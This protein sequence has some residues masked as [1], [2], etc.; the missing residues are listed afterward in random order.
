MNPNSKPAIALVD[1][2]PA[3]REA[4]A[5]LLEDNGFT[6]LARA[7]GR[8]E[9]LDISSNQPDLMLVDIS[10]G[11]EDGLAIVENMQL[12]GIP[13]VVCSTH[14]EP[15]YVRRALNAGA[16]GYVSKRDAGQYLARAIRDVL[17]G[18]VMISLRAADDLSDNI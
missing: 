5:Q 17:N 7:S 16:R 14:E 4:L 8:S 9:E 2:H 15:E 10:L 6:V 18:W 3:V 11:D 12:P 1:N 13:V